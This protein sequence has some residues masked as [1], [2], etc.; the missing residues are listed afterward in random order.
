[1]ISPLS[2]FIKLNVIII[3]NFYFDTTMDKIISII[4]ML[5]SI[6]ALFANSIHGGKYGALAHISKLNE[7][8]MKVLSK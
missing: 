1:M 7:Y 3:A 4:L 5:I 6:I 8:L 2:F